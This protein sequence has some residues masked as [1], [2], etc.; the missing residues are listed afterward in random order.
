MGV[1]RKKGGRIEVGRKMVLK[2][3]E[4]GETAGEAEREKTGQS[5]QRKKKK[6]ERGE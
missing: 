2:K 3:R 5:E 6:G 4:D 1:T